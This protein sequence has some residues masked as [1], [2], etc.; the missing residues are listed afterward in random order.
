MRR[1]QELAA[2]R[3]ELSRASS[4]TRD[5]SQLGPDHPVRKLLARFRRI[6]DD[7]NTASGPDGSDARA[8]NGG[9]LGVAIGS[10]AG[11]GAGAG[12]DRKNN[13]DGA[14]NQL[15]PHTAL[16]AAASLNAGANVQRS[17]SVG[18]K[19]TGQESDQHPP[20]QA[21]RSAEPVLRRQPPIAPDA[22]EGS[23][24]HT[25]LQQ[26][27][28]QLRD[29]LVDQSPP[30]SERDTE[31]DAENER[32]GGRRGHQP[33]A[34]SSGSAHLYRKRTEIMRRGAAWSVSGGDGSSG[35]SSF[36]FN[37]E[38]VQS[39]RAISGQLFELR[40]EWRREVGDLEARLERNDEQM[41][42]LEELVGL[43]LSS[44]PTRCQKMLR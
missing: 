6:S 38:I 7:R 9:L 26:Q 21:T 39:L 23:I 35:D 27:L 31:Q 42:L 10:S 25:Q 1:E 3:G 44:A 11:P 18:T 16:S 30:D 20:L 43:I 4:T 14:I 28:L 2:K 15:S 32:G 13:S 29:T 33:L 5:I 34:S 24:R 41:R 8:N 19:G 36:A 17:A 37:C 22:R 40:D 12:A